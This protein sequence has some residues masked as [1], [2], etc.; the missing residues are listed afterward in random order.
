M[1][2]LK[3]KI[4]ALNKLSARPSTNEVSALAYNLKPNSGVAV[5]LAVLLMGVFL[6]I[7]LTLSAIFIPKIRTAGD[8]KRSVAAAYAAESGIEWCLYVN[9]KG[10]AAT[11]V[12]S[13][14]ATY[15]NGNT[16]VSFVPAD[17]STSPIKS[18]GTYQGVTRTFEVSL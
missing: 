6:S 15:I 9:R 1:F 8:V 11:P 12:M 16:G 2:N 5:I 13:N 17:C 10:S 18:L 4:K 7:T 14:G 3:P